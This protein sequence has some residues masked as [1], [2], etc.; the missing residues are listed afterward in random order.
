MAS[1]AALSGHILSLTYGLRARG[2]HRCGVALFKSELKSTLYIGRTSS[3]S[4]GAKDW[5][6]T[7][8]AQLFRLP[9]YLLSY[10]RIKCWWIVQES[11]LA[12]APV[13]IQY[14]TTWESN[15]HTLHLLP[16]V[17]WRPRESNPSRHDACK[18]T[19]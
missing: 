13:A 12:S 15:P 19:P 1:P 2:L 6:R 9:L 11:N 8:D 16:N 17:W 10:R 4:D 3:N 5:N 7:S 14:H 18:A